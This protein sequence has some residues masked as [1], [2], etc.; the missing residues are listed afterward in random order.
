MNL[1][2]NARSCPKSRAL[3]ANRVI[4]EHV[5]VASVAEQFGVSRST[6]YKWGRR[7]RDWGEAGLGD[8]SSSPGSYAIGLDR[9]AWI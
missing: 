4:K 8:L 1:H 5:S 7:Y 9:M 3:M 2:K 6:V